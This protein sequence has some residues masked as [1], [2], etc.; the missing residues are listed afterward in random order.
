MVFRDDDSQ[1]VIEMLVA[2][3]DLRDG[4]GTHDLWVRAA[5]PRDLVVT[6]VSA[7]GWQEDEQDGQA[8][9]DRTAIGDH[10]VGRR[11]MAASSSGLPTASVSPAGDAAGTAGEAKPARTCGAPARSPLRATHSGR[12]TTVARSRRVHGQRIIPRT[13]AIATPTDPVARRWRSRVDQCCRPARYAPERDSTIW[14]LRLLR[15]G[16][17]HRTV[18]GAFDRFAAVGTDPL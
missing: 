3:G 12:S 1:A 2:E 4:V 17:V 16:G 15:A 14:M 11:P 10:D 6:I 5:G 7:S 9:G 8:K 18:T 13:T